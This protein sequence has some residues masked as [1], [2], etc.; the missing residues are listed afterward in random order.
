V[1]PDDPDPL[2]EQLQQ[3]LAQEGPAQANIDDVAALLGRH[4]PRRLQHV[5]QV[6]DGQA[7]LGRHGISLT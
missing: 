6:V 1:T 4:E 3:L 2:E 7:R 5:A